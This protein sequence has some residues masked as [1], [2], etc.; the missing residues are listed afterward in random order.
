VSGLPQP[1]G[2]IVAVAVSSF[3]PV[4][5]FYCSPVPTSPSLVQPQKERPRHRKDGNVGNQP[6]EP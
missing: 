2:R 4:R 6:G 5:L 1:V 3:S